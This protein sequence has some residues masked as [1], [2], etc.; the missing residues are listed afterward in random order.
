M[1]AIFLFV[2]G[3]YTEIDEDHT[4]IHDPVVVQ[5][6]VLVNEAVAVHLFDCFNHL[7]EDV[8]EGQLAGDASS[9]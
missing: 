2:P 7:D 5:L 4:V 9:V 8:G 1:P 3:C 6:N